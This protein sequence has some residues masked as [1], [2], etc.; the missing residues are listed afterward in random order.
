MI[1]TFLLSLILILYMAF[2]GLVAGGVIWEGKI[3]KVI[4]HT[5]RAIPIAIAFNAV[6]GGDWASILVLVWSAAWFW[7]GHKDALD[8][9]GGS[10]TDDRDNFLTPFVLR[11]AGKLKYERSSLNYDLLFWF[12]KC[13]LITLPIGGTGGLFV[14]PLML[15]AHKYI[16]Y[17]YRAPAEMIARAL[18]ISLSILIFVQVF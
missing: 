16:A 4:T 15:A 10:P 12:V 5:L 3:P 17:E 18:G 9:G 8:L 7:T 6:F 11:I 13:S 14:P 2:L 1:M